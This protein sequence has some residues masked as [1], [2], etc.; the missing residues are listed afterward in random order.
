MLNLGRNEMKGF[1]EIPKSNYS[2]TLTKSEVLSKT[3]IYVVI[4]AY[5]IC[6]LLQNSGSVLRT[7]IGNRMWWLSSR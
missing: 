2:K 7:A 3:N 6:R 5:D 1:F 4:V